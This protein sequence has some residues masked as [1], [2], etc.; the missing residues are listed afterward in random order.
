MDGEV[1]GGGGGVKED[2]R[3]ILNVN[4]RVDHYM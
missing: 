3:F 2:I 1:N 4:F